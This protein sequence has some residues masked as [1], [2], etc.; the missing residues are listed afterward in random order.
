MA[1][2]HSKILDAPPGAQILSISCS[3]WENLAK[4]C[5]GAPLEGWR[6]LLGEILDPPLGMSVEGRG[7]YV[8]EEV[9]ISGEWVCPEVGMSGS[10]YVWG[11]Y[12][13]W[14]LKRGVGTPPSMWNYG[15]WLASGL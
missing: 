15:I 10:G 3:F 4:S 12:P 9:D 13:I 6:P 5:V 8:P 2:L 11:G 14:D 7:G 1:H